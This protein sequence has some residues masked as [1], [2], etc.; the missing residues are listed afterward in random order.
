MNDLF[1]S[2]TRY[3]PEIFCTAESA[4]M[5]LSGESYPENSWDFYQPLFDWMHLFLLSKG[6][7]ITFN[8]KLTYYNT[9]S[10]KVLLELLEILEKYH[11]RMGDVK[12]NWYYAEDD[13]DM[14]EDGKGFSGDVTMIPFEFIPVPAKELQSA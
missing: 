12:V 5:Q 2:K 7:S 14:L 10:T 6:R 9:S 11:S 1:I 3:T 13:E 8:C 4:V